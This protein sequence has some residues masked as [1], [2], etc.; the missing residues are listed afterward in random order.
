MGA[1]YFDLIDVMK[2]TDNPE[3]STEAGVIGVGWASAGGEATAIFNDRYLAADGI[4]KWITEGI[5]RTM[6]QYNG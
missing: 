4:E 1:I 6:S 3:K 5:D 2:R